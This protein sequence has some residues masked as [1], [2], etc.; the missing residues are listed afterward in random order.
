MLAAPNQQ[1]I[2]RLLADHRRRMGEVLDRQT[3]ILARV[4][5]TLAR[6]LTLVPQS[7]EVSVREIAEVTVI[8]LRGESGP[9]LDELTDA[10]V[11]CER[12]LE[13]RLRDER[14][15]SAGPLAVIHDVDLFA[16]WYSRARFE[17]CA[18]LDSSGPLPA[19]AW[20]LPGCIAACTVHSGPR[21][22]LRA[23]WAALL[24][25]IE[26]SAYTAVPPVRTTYFVGAEDDDDPASA[27]TH[28][29]MPVVLSDA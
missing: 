10:R 6:G 8:S 7:Y 22:G 27:I 16:P 25:W 29:A 26:R 1:S 12:Q 13:K 21:D 3:A 23:S 15:V 14:L 2:E 9:S 4:E 11:A 18:P 17:V 5:Q 28:L 19:D 24:A 20:H